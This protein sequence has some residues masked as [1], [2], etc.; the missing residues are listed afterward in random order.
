MK[1]F[2]EKHAKSSALAL[3]L[4][5]HAILIVIATGFVAVKVLITPKVN[6]RDVSIPH[7][8]PHIPINLKPF[9]PSK[10]HAPRPNIKPVRV[11]ITAIKPA[12]FPIPQ[13]A[14][15]P[16][17]M[18]VSRDT[19]DTGLQVGLQTQFQFFETKAQGEKV[20]FIVHFGPAT[21]GKTPFSRMTGYTI[22]K[23]LNEIVSRLPEYAL[24]NVATYWAADTCAMAPNM[25]VASETNKQ[26]LR[27]WM[28]SA[29]PLEGNYDHCFHWAEATA[30]IE[31]AKN[32]WPTRVESLPDY[33]TQWAYPYRV[34]AALEE[35]Y[36]GKDTPFVHWGRAV[37]WAILTQKPDTIFILTT[38]YIDGWGAGN[39]GKPNKMV[40]GYED[41]LRDTYG[42][43]RKTWPTLN[44]V[45]LSQA[46]KDT[47]R[48]HE[49]LNG[50]FGLLV[51]AFHGSGAVIEDIADYM[52]PDE[53][54]LLKQY[55]KEFDQ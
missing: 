16:I 45:V 44:V 15:I 14:M 49:I 6:F 26:M 8:R 20:C 38:N 34:P 11:K 4:A 46:G 21:L 53:K 37:A 3:T 18:V 47:D 36:L 25:K 5:L 39:R 24:F 55:A 52:N 50:Q 51:N 29:N 13:V 1:R 40:D 9:Q 28:E 17:P 48:A 2:F 27:D 23:R 32:H 41:M 33:S 54:E 10:Q 12:P 43:D 42:P 30:R 35:K 19:T 22:R 31:S 7:E